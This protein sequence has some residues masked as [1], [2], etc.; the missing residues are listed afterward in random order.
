M[1]Q[2]RAAATARKADIAALANIEVVRFGE[3]EPE[4]WAHRTKMSE[5]GI[6]LELFEYIFLARRDDCITREYPIGHPLRTR[7][8]GFRADG[9][10][11]LVE[12]CPSAEYGLAEQAYAPIAVSWIEVTDVNDGQLT[13]RFSTHTPRFNH[14]ELRQ[15]GAEWE[16]VVDS[17]ASR[18]L[19]ATPGRNVVELR[20]VN[21]FGIAGQVAALE[22]SAPGETTTTADA[23]E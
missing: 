9:R 23:D 6:N 20:A 4:L 14:F 15:R 17:R 12:V 11:D 18:T 8:L 19:P 10:H 1:S 13:L 5:S 3:S 2:R 21:S 22:I 7:Q 16:Q